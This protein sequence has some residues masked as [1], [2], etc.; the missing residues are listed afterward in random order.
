MPIF[1]ANLWQTQNISIMCGM[2][3]SSVVPRIE[4]AINGD[5]ELIVT[6]LSISSKNSMTMSTLFMKLNLYGLVI[7]WTQV[8]HARNAPWSIDV[9][10]GKR[11]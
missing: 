8:A 3:N 11:W 1:F 5:A 7:A 10:V 4:Y 6:K 2:S 9:C